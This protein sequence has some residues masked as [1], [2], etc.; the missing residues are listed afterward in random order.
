M[1]GLTNEIERW[2]HQLLRETENGIVEIGRNELAQ[3]F[4]CAPSQINYVLTTRFTPYKGYT[5]ESRRGGAGYIRIVKV[6]M[7]SEDILKDI[8][9]N[10]IGDQIT[11][12][13]ALH[14]INRLVKDKICTK[15][16]AMI[17]LQALEDTSLGRVKDDRN[18]VR[19]DM[20]RN[21]LMVFFRKEATP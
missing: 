12:D 6:T 7:D 19:A 21:M 10:T 3:H 20:L 9:Q 14:I 8:V 2:I 17:M 13:R 16:E 4:G 11:K 15:N 5:I 18:S 1:A